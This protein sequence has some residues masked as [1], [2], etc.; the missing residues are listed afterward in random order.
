M[1]LYGS[2]MPVF[3]NNTSQAREVPILDE[4]GEETGEFKLEFAPP[5]LIFGHISPAVEEAE[6]M[7]FGTF[8]D[9]SLILQLSQ[10]EFHEY[11]IT[12][13]TKVLIAPRLKAME[14]FN[15]GEREPSED[16]VPYI[17]RRISEGVQW[18]RF[19]LSEVSD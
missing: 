8:T 11:E 3:L 2:L 17:V 10:R 13:Q 9:Y 15:N 14:R 16:H 6:E 7:P 1:L 5:R 4:N 18:V 19:A 12:E